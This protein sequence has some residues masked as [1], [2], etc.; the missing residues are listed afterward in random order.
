MIQDQPGHDRRQAQLA[1]IHIA[2]KQLGLD[3]EAYRAM[4]WTVAR[5][6]SSKD[7]DEHGRER[8]I[9]HLR[10]GGFK[11]AAPAR[12]QFPGRPHNVDSSPQLR[13]VEAL[14]A[15]AGRPW[16]YADSLSKSMF[17]VDRVAWCNP[18]QL[19]SLIA[20][21]VMDQRRRRKKAA[22]SAGVK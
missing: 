22:E 6:R 2:K 3:D 5:V 10:R 17:N 1:K 9:E 14:L 13:K 15:D 20:A 8:V 16:D 19:Q 18:A 21:L 4:L 7:L 12:G 11:P